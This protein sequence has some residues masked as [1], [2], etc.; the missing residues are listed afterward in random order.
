[1]TAGPVTGGNTRNKVMGPPSARGPP[2]SFRRPL[3]APRGGFKNYLKSLKGPIK[4]LIR[5]LRMKTICKN[6]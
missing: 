5:L 6:I 4:T 3:R 2:K 1:M